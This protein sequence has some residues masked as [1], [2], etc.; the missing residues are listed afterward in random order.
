M[1]LLSSFVIF[2]FLSLQSFGQEGLLIRNIKNGNAWMYEKNSRV[3]YI[4]FK[5]DEYTTGILHALL[6]SAVVFGKDTV[7][8]KEIAGVRKKNPI[9]FL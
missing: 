8:L 3:T 5:E 9:H 4:K 1:K 6:D 2:I 7:L